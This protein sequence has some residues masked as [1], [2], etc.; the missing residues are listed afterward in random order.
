MSTVFFDSCLFRGLGVWTDPDTLDFGETFRGTLHVTGAN[1]TMA[2]R[3]CT[4]QSMPPA[5][6]IGTSFAASF[7]SDNPQQTVRTS[8]GTNT[9]T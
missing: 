7:F 8:L 2:M 5:W 6:Q 3:N 4:L 1:A 9:N